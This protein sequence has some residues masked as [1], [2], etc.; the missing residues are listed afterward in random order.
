MPGFSSS[1]TTSLTLLGRLQSDPDDGVAWE[2]FVS[3]YGPLIRRWCQRWGL[4]VADGEDVTQNILLALSKQMKRYEKRDGVR[5][6]GWLKTIA[7]RAW[8]DFQQSRRRHFQGSGDDD[9]HRMLLSV[10]AGE[11]F[12]DEMEKECDR[13]LLDDAMSIVRRRTQQSTWTAFHQTAFEKRSGKEVS[14]DLGMS[15]LA[16]YQARSRVQAMIKA[17]FDRLDTMCTDS[18][19]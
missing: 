3:R 7:H 4:Q 6:R 5:F 13:N 12:V 9:V 2:E 10:E 16:V 17:E 18:T 1:S 14:E 8:C 11:D 15:V 19:R